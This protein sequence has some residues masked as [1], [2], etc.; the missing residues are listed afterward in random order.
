MRDQSTIQGASTVVSSLMW[1]LID[2]SLRLMIP[3]I[4][5]I[6]LVVGADF[7]A[8]LRKSLKLHVHISISTAFRSTMGKLVTYFAF[9][10]AVCFVDVSAN[11]GTAIAKWSCLFICG[12]EGLSVIGNILKPYGIDLSLKTFVKMFAI[13]R[14]GLDKDEAENIVKEDRIEIIRRREEKK[15][16]SR[17]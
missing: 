1:L 17:K 8:G 16:N 10:C 14:L 11:G 6:T 13:R 15:W 5:A 3:W 9:V 12:I 7:V 2:Q 4:I